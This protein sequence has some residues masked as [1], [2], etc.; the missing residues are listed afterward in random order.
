MFPVFIGNFMILGESTRLKKDMASFT[1][2]PSPPIKIKTINLTAAVN[3]SSDYKT[4]YKLYCKS[5]P[6]IINCLA[7]ARK[8]NTI[9]AHSMN[10]VDVFLPGELGVYF[11]CEVQ[12]LNF[13]VVVLRT[14]TAINLPPATVKEKTATKENAHVC[15]KRRPV[16]FRAGFVDADVFSGRSGRIRQQRW[17]Y[18]QSLWRNWN[19]IS[20]RETQW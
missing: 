8:N 18:L 19:R 3:T 1:Q 16:L 5:L 6:C 10:W 9:P 4:K 17:V 15:G 14:V 20:G 7:E 13:R 12:R 2:T 11:Y